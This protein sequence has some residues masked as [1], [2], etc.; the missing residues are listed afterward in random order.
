MVPAVLGFDAIPVSTTGI[1][2]NWSNESC[3]TFMLLPLYHR[4][5]GLVV[6]STRYWSG[7]INQNIW[8]ARDALLCVVKANRFLGHFVATAGDSWVS[9]SY[10]EAFQKYATLN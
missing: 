8:D 7:K 10:D 6:Q 3:F 2:H 4:L 1:G 9:G 5:S